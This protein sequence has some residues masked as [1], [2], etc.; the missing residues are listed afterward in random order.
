MAT[1][2]QVNLGYIPMRLI[3]WQLKE[4]D[5]CP[6]VTPLHLNWWLQEE[7]ILQ[8]QP[9]PSLRHALQFLQMHQR[10]GGALT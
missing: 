2:K 9:I 7:N 10:K 4:G 8:G 3:Q 1:G 5:P 6:H